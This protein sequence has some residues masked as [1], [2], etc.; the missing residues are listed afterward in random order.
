MRTNLPQDKSQ[1]CSL[2]SVS[3]LIQEGIRLYL[4]ACSRQCGRFLANLLEAILVHVH[5]LG[6]TADPK[7]PEIML[8][9]N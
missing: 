1:H 6:P 3:F 7:S 8:Q 9:G 4:A 5:H 2:V